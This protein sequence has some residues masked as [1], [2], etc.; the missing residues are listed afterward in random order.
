MMEFVVTKRERRADL[1]DMVYY[2]A[3]YDAESWA[4]SGPI[5]NRTITPRAV[6]NE[7][8][9]DA[10]VKQLTELGHAVKKEPRW[11]RPRHAQAS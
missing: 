2:Y 9:A 5:F 11:K 8:T 6:F 3:G 1:P 10:I 7:V 4:I